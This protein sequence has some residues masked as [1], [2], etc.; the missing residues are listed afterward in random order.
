M[1]AAL[2]FPSLSVRLATAIG[3]LSRGLAN[4]LPGNLGRAALALSAW[5][6]LRRLLARFTALVAAVEAGRLTAS[7]NRTAEAGRVPAGR[8]RAL[9]ARPR[10]QAAA[11][12]L[13]GGSGWLLRFAP[14]PDTRLGRAE[15]EALLADPDLAALLAQ[16]PQAGRILRPLCRMLGIET[17]AALRLPRRPRRRPDDPKRTDMGEA[18]GDSRPA[19]PPLPSRLPPPRSPPLPRRAEAPAA[20]TPD[21]TRTG[22]P[23]S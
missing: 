17:P 2:A 3:L 15:V 8:K 23:R 19:R 7:R 13:P 10:P 18:G 16:A 6:R 9:A 1:S 12:R 20:A 11:V 21:P 14:A 4:S 22:P 5:T